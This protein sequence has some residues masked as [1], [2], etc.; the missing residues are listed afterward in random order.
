MK[1]S[2]PFTS[3]PFIGLIVIVAIGYTMLKLNTKETFNAVVIGKDS[4]S[5]GESGSQYRIETEDE[6]FKNVDAPFLGKWDSSDVQRKATI[7]KEH[8]IT[9]YGW[10]VPFLS[11]YRNIVTLKV[12]E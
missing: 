6:T 7:G 12:I 11:M 4:V 9:A 1:K 2:N 8:T 5:M 3:L 10:R